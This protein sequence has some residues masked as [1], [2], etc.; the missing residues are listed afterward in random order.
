RTRAEFERHAREVADLWG[1]RLLQ[2]RVVFLAGSDLLHRPSDEIAAYLDALGRTFPI[3]PIA[4]RQADR[5]AEIDEAAPRLDGIH[6]FLDDFNPPLPDRTAWS[7][8]AAGGLTRV[9]LG[10]ESG[11]PEIRRVYRKRWED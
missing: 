4:D 1:R 9:S 6:A 7:Q 8:L 5:R 11:D 3:Q 2:S 10:I